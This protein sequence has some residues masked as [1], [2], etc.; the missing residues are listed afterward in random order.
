MHSNDFLLLLV[1]ISDCSIIYCFS[2]SLLLLIVVFV[3]EL[4]KGFPKNTQSA[5]SETNPAHRIVFRF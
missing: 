3:F 5:V 1:Y 2:I 4:K